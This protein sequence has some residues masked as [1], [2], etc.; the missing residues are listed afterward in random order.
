MNGARAAWFDAPRLAV[1]TKLCGA[2]L[3]LW[4]FR[5]LERDWRAAVRA[6]VLSLER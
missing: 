1:W 5:R 4:P 6:R 3:A 2:S